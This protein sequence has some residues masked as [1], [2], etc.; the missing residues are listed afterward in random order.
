MVLF[1]FFFLGG[2]GLG[3]SRT[4]L[5]FPRSMC[6]FLSWMLKAVDQEQGN[7]VQIQCLEASDRILQSLYT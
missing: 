3:L 4:C 6:L 1:F 2:G 5:V 7:E